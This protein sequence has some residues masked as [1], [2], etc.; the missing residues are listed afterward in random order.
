MVAFTQYNIIFRHWCFLWLQSHPFSTVTASANLSPISNLELA[1]KA[2]IFQGQELNMARTP[3]GPSSGSC[4][5]LLTIFNPHPWSS[6]PIDSY[7]QCPFILSPLLQPWIPCQT[8][9][10]CLIVSSQLE[11]LPHISP[12]FIPL[13]ILHER[14]SNCTYL[15]PIYVVLLPLFIIAPH[16]PVSCTHFREHESVCWTLRRKYCFFNF[17]NFILSNN[18]FIYVWASLVAQLVKNPP[19][20]RVDLVSIPG[21]GRSPGEGKGYPL[22]AYIL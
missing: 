2:F 13:S 14:D 4:L 7:F 11:F 3:K 17:L 18:Y 16:S 8:S 19:A 10:F 1:F 9:L 6:H 21:L 12:G 22:K 20:M 5:R 15:T